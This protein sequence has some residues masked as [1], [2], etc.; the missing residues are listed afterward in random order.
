MS[1]QQYPAQQLIQDISSI[2]MDITKAIEDLH[3]INHLVS[4]ETE[5]I[6]YEETFCK[7]C[8]EPCGRSNAEIF[9]CMMAKLNQKQN[10]EIK[11]YT[12]E[13]LEHDLKELIKDLE[14]KEKH[15]Q[16]IVENIQ[17]HNPHS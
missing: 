1:Y 10:H 12:K 11:K 4:N 17:K 8:K 13:Y 15:L 5:I 7:Q 9:N 14:E 2:K 6:S 16:K 3:H